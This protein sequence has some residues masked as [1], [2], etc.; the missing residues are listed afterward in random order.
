MCAYEEVTVLTVVVV[1]GIALVL[2]ITT[3]SRPPDCTE[4]QRAYTGG[5]RE[6][7]HMPGTVVARVRREEIER[8]RDFTALGQATGSEGGRSRVT[9]I[10]GQKPARQIPCRQL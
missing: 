5:G 4:A 1:L 3:F 7:W 9:R 8:Q 2:V 10:A 6:G